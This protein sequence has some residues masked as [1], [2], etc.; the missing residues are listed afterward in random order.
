MTVDSWLRLARSVPG[1]Y[2]LI[3]LLA[4]RRIVVRGDSMYPALRPGERVLFDRLAYRIDD[5]QPGEVVLAR[6]P[7]RP[8]VRFLKRV[9]AVHADGEYWL[10]GDNPDASTDSR[11]LGA[12]RR[13]DI[14]ARAWW[15]YW[16]PDLMRRLP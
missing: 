9:A 3:A 7:A 14:V 12:F 16:P 8:G 13:G 5:P 2:T 4:A 6:H 15:V 11:Q 1:A 10:L